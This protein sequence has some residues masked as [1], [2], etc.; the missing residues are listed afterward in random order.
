MSQEFF[1]LDNN[2]PEYMTLGDA[3]NCVE[4]RETEYIG[5]KEAYRDQMRTLMMTKEDLEIAVEIPVDIHNAQLA[6]P[7][8]H[9][10]N[11]LIKRWGQS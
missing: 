6:G 2:H 7:I 1:N 10:R 11:R 5:V 9:C 8:K 4:N 3:G